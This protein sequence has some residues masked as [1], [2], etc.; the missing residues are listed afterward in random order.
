MRKL[1][2]SDLMGLE[3]YHEARPEF[4]ERV[5]AHKQN[6]QVAVGP[7]ATLYFEDQLTV[8]YQ[9]QEMLRI[10][11]IFESEAIN[12]ELEAYVPLIPDGSNLKATFMVEFPD[13]EE[14]R[15][16]LMRLI[17]I[18]GKVYVQVSGFD[19]IYA[20]ADEDLERATEEKTSAVHFVRFELAL[21]MRKALKDG[22]ELRIG[23]DH[24][25]YRHFVDPVSAVVRNSLVADLD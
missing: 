10:E 23:I 1:Q 17:G 15:R 12:E 8:Q 25:N 24:P 3:K 18:E 22:A 19:R 4:R 9:V 2:A 14:R 5:L 21:I 11:K 20:I 7:N 16:E 6:R 13:P